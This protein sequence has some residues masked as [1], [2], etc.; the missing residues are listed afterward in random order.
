[1]SRLD[2]LIKKVFETVYMRVWFEFLCEVF[3]TNS[4]RLC[5]LHLKVSCLDCCSCN[6]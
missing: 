3:D 1:M 5:S 4:S 6:S 2:L